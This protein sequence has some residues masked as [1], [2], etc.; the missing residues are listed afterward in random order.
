MLREWIRR[1]RWDLAFVDDNWQFRFIQTGFRDR[2]FADPFILSVTDDEVVLLAEEFSYRIGRGRIAR[3]SVDRRSL[4]MTDMEI[5][6]DLPTHLSFPAIFRQGDEVFVYP[7]NSASGC[8]TLYRYRDELRRMEPVSVLSDM[9]L[10][11]AV[12]FEKDGRKLL[13]STFLPLPN[14]R[15]LGLFRSD[16]VLGPYKKETEVRFDDFVA[17]NSG[18]IFQEKGEF[19]RPAQIGDGG[20]GY[21]LGIEFQR[22]A[23]DGDAVLFTPVS[24]HYPPE[25]YD[26][27]HTYNSLD[28]WHVVDCRRYLR[29]C[30]RN[31]LHRIKL[32]LQR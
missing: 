20:D 15:C 28:G 19:I 11:D 14:G 12:L 31:T 7:E 22:L 25:G 32:L 17:R 5:V 26:G 9:P 6:L 1:H 2:W 29:P 24:R 16:D 10:T 23:F 4:K 30:L 13:L 8:C 21:G 18:L 3:L 27:M